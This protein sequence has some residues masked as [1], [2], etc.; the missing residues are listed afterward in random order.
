MN[1]ARSFF[2]VGLGVLLSPGIACGQGIW[3]G[4]FRDDL[5]G[6]ALDSNVWSVLEANGTYSLSNGFLASQV[7]RRDRRSPPWATK[8][9]TGRTFTSVL[10]AP[11]SP[12]PMSHLPCVGKLIRL[13]TGFRVCFARSVAFGPAA[14]GWP[15]GGCPAAD[16]A[17]T[18]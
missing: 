7:V 10:V 1:R 3:A 11:R 13:A 16:C 15:E 9:I 17:V 6:P 14:A 2:Y 18:A 5:N 4:V 8:G 12:T